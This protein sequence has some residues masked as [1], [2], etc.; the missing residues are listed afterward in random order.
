MVEY[1]K[2]EENIPLRQVNNSLPALII[3]YDLRNGDS[4]IVEKRIDFSNPE[5]RKWLGRI[6]FWAMTHHCS[7]ETLAIVDAEAEH[8]KPREN[9]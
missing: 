1:R 9:V 5:D 3:V 4:P 2:G 7:V 8:I 6:S